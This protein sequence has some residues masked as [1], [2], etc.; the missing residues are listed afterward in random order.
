[1]NAQRR[2]GSSESLSGDAPVLR[3]AL[4]GR[5]GNARLVLDKAADC[6]GDFGKLD[7]SAFCMKGKVRDCACHLV[8]SLSLSL[9][10]S[11]CLSVSLSH[12]FTL[13]LSHTHTH[14]LIFFL[15]FVLFVPLSLS[16]SLSLCSLYISYFFQHSFTQHKSYRWC[17]SQALPSC[18]C[19]APPKR[20]RMSR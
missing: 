18:A 6:G 1:M 13:S 10:L 11:L 4:D 12:C 20:S 5:H 16:L 15:I 7:S 19:S 2:H 14:S 3:A 9:C 8:G 17:A